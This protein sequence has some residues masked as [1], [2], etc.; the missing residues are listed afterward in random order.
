M[1]GGEETKVNAKDDNGQKEKE[2]KVKG[3]SQTKRT[4]AVVVF[5]WFGVFFSVAILGV[6]MYHGSERR[7][8][9][10][11]QIA[12]GFFTYLGIYLFLDKAKV[13]D[14]YLLQYYPEE[15]LHSVKV[16]WN[17]RVI[18]CIN[19]ALVTFCGLYG[20]LVETDLVFAPVTGYPSLTPIFGAYLLAY[21]FFDLML[22]L[23]YL[24]DLGDIP[25]IVHHIMIAAWLANSGLFHVNFGA[26]TFFM[27]NEISTIFLNFRWFFHKIVT[28]PKAKEGAISSALIT[29]NLLL[30]ASSFFFSR[31]I[32]NIY[33]AYYALQEA[34][35]L[36]PAHV[37]FKPYGTPSFIFSDV[38]YNTK[39]VIGFLV[40]ILC[41]LNL[42]WFCTVLEKA[43]EV[44]RGTKIKQA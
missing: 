13:F 25:I 8:W 40:P 28:S 16:G 44:I 30:F 43:L 5:G 4:P 10:I 18:S 20:L 7:Y 29:A 32:G 21:C 38:E 22:V 11:R 1:L 17:S 9:W 15:E 27:T 24:E 37:F 41:I 35:A 42:W 6:C 39:F 23:W 3:Q 34:F 26:G 31:V 36:T 12:R 14:D 19:A 2:Q 33:I